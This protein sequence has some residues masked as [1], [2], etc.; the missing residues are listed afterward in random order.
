MDR[1]R[2][3]AETG[4]NW[5]AGGYAVVGGSDRGLARFSLNEDPVRQTGAMNVGSTDDSADRGLQGVEL[6]G[7]NN[8][9]NE[10]GPLPVHND[11]LVIA[12]RLA[13]E[14]ARVAAGSNSCCMAVCGPDTGAGRFVEHSVAEIAD[15]F[16]RCLRSYDSVHRFGRDRIVIC[17]PHLQS[18]EAAGV[19]LRLRELVTRA[20][21]SLPN[22]SSALITAT[23]GGAMM[24]AST[25]VHE[26]LNRAD[27]AKDMSR[28]GGDNR[29]LMWS[30][31]MF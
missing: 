30:P 12:T 27:R 31:D 16:S 13:A 4:K 10:Q 8:R 7:P 19:L 18:A 28:L 26:T 17:L 1:F 3:A 15:R 20:P 24:D 5:S 6:G 11:L 25:P 23:L 9:D 29:V 2:E 22:G 21:F 14:Q